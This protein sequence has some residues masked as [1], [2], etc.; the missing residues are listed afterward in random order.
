MFQQLNGELKA[1]AKAYKGVGSIFGT[2][3]NAYGGVGALLRSPY[4]HATLI[5]L[6]PL[7]FNTWTNGASV[8]WWEHAESALPNLLGFSL[9]GFA[10]FIGFGDDK[11]RAILAEPENDPSRTTIYLG[12]CSTFV[13]FIVIQVTAFLWAYGSHALYFYSPK[14]DCLRAYLPYLNGVNGAIGYGLF[15]YALMSILAATMHVFRIAKMYS[16]YIAWLK[17]QPK[18]TA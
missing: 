12:M 7:T 6:L 5:F 10:I 14:M 15:L 11:F 17:S 2:Y 16:D 3:W 9:A 4:L 8:K 1:I 13:H 18:K